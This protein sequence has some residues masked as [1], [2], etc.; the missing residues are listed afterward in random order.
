MEVEV[1]NFQL[2]GEI[3]LR[4][5]PHVGLTASDGAAGARLSCSFVTPPNLSLVLQSR[6]ALGGKSL[7]FQ[8]SIEDKLTTKLQRMMMNAICEKMVGANWHVLADDA[9]KQQLSIALARY[10]HCAYY[11]NASCCD[12]YHDGIDG[13]QCER[14]PF[15]I[16]VLMSR[17]DIISHSHNSMI[18]MMMSV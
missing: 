7:P 2:S 6:V 14:Y 13:N 8:K 9:N 3:R 4:S 5:L 17:Y 1:G 18:P 16:M 10:P 11:H 15:G 12:V